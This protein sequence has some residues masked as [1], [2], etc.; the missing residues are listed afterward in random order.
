MRVWSFVDSLL[1]VL[2]SQSYVFTREFVSES[3]SNCYEDENRR[4]SRPTIPWGLGSSRLIQKYISI[5]QKP[6]NY[7]QCNDI[8]TFR[9]KKISCNDPNPNPIYDNRTAPMLSTS[10]MDT[11]I[12]GIFSVSGIHVCGQSD[13]MFMF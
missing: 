12:F 11:G 8:T 1:L 4:Q 5:V 7:T 9:S 3:I 6:Q 13:S 10:H 2:Q